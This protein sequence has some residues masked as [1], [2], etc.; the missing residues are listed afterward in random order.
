MPW[1]GN[2]RKRLVKTPK[3]HFYD[4]GL[5]CWLLGIRSVDQLHLHPL[6]GAIFETWVVSEIFKHRTNRGESNGLFF[7]RDRHGLEADALIDEPT[8]KRIVETKAGQTV[9]SDMVG[10]CRK[11]ANTLSD[12]GPVDP[13]VVYAGDARQA[14]HDVV[15]LPWTDLHTWDW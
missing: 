2:V 9:T 1:S 7:I 14:R 10:S 5:L 12:L 15:I 11:I 13:V 8:R 6:R 4:T 3:L